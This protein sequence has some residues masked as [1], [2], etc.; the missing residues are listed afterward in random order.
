M[1][2]QKQRCSYGNDTNL[3]RI[4]V[5]AYRRT[6]TSQQNIFRSMGYQKFLRYGASLRYS[7]AVT[8]IST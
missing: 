4:K 7:S 1:D 2:G 5:S 8:Q 3:L 6:V